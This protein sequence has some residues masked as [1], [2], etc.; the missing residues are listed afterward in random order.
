MKPKA[1][2]L[3]LAA[4][5]VELGWC[6]GKLVDQDGNHCM[7]GAIA[8]AATRM[9]IPLNYYLTSSSQQYYDATKPYLPALGFS[10][11]DRAYC[12]NDVPEQTKEAV[13]A[14]LRE[15]AKALRAEQI[16]KLRGEDS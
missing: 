3:E 16:K 4:D 8:V 5:L 13:A 12:F 15:G 6:R 1:N 9:P 2:V 14:K 11:T 10:T 7:L